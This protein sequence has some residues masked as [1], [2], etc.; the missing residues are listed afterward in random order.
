MSM[1][2][3]KLEDRYIVVKKKR[4]NESQIGAIEAVVDAIGERVD[5]IVIEDDWPEYEPVFQML[6]DRVEGLPNSYSEQIEALSE[7]VRVIESAGLQNLAKGV[8]LGQA[9]WWVKATDA[10]N[11]AKAVIS[12]RSPDL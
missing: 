7:L 8:Q 11:Y 1:S 2:E 3:F 10:V 12:A 4:L 5:C 9:S 6:R